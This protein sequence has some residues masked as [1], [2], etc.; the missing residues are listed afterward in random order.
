[1]QALALSTR[2][3]IKLKLFIL[4]NTEKQELT[5]FSSNNNYNKNT[6]YRHFKKK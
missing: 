1:M 3:K 2:T 6:S 5:F 4:K